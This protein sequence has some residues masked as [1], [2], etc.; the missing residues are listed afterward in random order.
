MGISLLFSSCD[1]AKEGEE[2]RKAPEIIK[3]VK[4]EGE[5]PIH[6][7]I[8]L[9]REEIQ[10]GTVAYDSIRGKLF[11]LPVE[12]SAYDCQAL[13]DCLKA[14]P[15]PY[16]SGL[17]WGAIFND[18]LNVLRSMKNPPRKFARQLLECYADES[19]SETI[20]NYALQ[21]F[22]SML[23]SYYRDPE[24]FGKIV[25]SNGEERREVE[26]A[27]KTALK[28]NNGVMMGTACNLAD[29]I[30]AACRESGLEPPVSVEDLAGNCRSIALS[31]E[32]NDHARITAFGFLGRHMIPNVVP[33]ARTYLKD[34]SVSVLLRAAAIHYVGVFK[35]VEDRPV[36]EELSK[37]GDLR[38]STPAKEGLKTAGNT[39]K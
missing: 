23:T 17:G 1:K 22:G 19:R 38:I 14:S 7:D 3:S 18:G 26:S 34:K 39:R 11:S 24:G 30:I 35:D 33:E 21:H 15:G 2:S 5:R 6:P 8:L 12:L 25:F 13:L 9:I 29:D 10:R 4:E 36:L 37:D 20:R 31:E 27:L 28:P 32:E 16:W